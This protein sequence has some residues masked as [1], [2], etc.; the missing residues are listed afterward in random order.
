MSHEP[1]PL[2]FVLCACYYLPCKAAFSTEKKIKIIFFLEKKEKKENCQKLKMEKKQ[3]KNSIK[4][5][6]N[7]FS[8]VL[9]CVL[10][11]KN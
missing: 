6:D 9:K 11:F 1:C 7:F 2:L 8:T 5:E 3:Q 10:N 4:V